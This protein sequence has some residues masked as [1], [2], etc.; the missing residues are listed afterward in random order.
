MSRV[1]NFNNAKLESRFAAMRERQAAKVAAINATKTFKPKKRRP[2][3]VKDGR[4]KCLRCKKKRTLDCYSPTKRYR[5]RLC[6]KCKERIRLA[7]NRKQKDSECSQRWAVNNKE[8][9]RA[10][11]QRR[12]QRNKQHILEVGKKWRIANRGKSAAATANY[13]ARKLAIPGS[14]TDEEWLAL[15]A[16]FEKRCVRCGEVKP[17][18]RDHVIPITKAGASNAICN[19][20]P[21]CKSCNSRKHTKALDYRRT[22]FQFLGLDAVSS[23]S[24]AKHEIFCNLHASGLNASDAYN[25]AYGG[26]K[27]ANVARASGARLLASVA[28]QQRVAE[29]KKPVDEAAKQVAAQIA[30]A[31]IQN[32]AK[33]IATYET[34]FDA[35]CE[36][37]A[38]RAN[39]PDNQEIPGIKTGTLAVA[40]EMLG[41]GKHGYE[42]KVARFDAALMRE[43]REIRKQMA[44]EIGEWSEKQDITV[45]Q[46][47]SKWTQ[48]QWDKHR[49]FLHEQALAAFGGD[50]ARFAA[51]RA[52]AL[53]EIQTT[54]ATQ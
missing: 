41:G 3:L 6:L 19:I 9:V 13:R 11:N 43:K 40:R 36:L 42:V 31:T 29:L 26:D 44:I 27:S 5:P 1:A 17:L 12:Y 32:K 7:S 14:H 15:C 39:D 30:D 24:N 35:I 4:L 47:T 33:R 38:A 49:N 54:G 21:L 8:R 46:D 20:Q 37:Q 53:E 51:F 10:N 2:R 18:A 25:Q 45:Q 52:K 22:P 28:I 23:L 34:D 50:E 48:E 16:K